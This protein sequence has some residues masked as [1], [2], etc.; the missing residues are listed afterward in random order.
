[1]PK[2]FPMKA[3]KKILLLN[4]VLDLRRIWPW[5]SYHTLIQMEDK[6]NELYVKP[7]FFFY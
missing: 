3:V 6:L 1:M 4:V 2:S 7:G 5:V